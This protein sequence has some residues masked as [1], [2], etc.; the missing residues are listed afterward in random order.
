MPRR[1]VRAVP[2][3][4]LC[5]I[6]GNWRGSSSAVERYA[7]PYPAAS[8]WPDTPPNPGPRQAWT[9]GPRVGGMPGTPGLWALRAAVAVWTPRSAFLQESGLSQASPLA[10]LEP[11]GDGGGAQ[12]VGDSET[13]GGL[14]PRRR[15]RRSSLVRSELRLPETFTRGRSG[16]APVHRCVR[17]SAGLAWFCQCCLH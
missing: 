15:I 10:G 5:S 7:L 12:V 9:A 13:L 3:N 8:A 14:W 6:T 2:G 16:W 11:P 1:G 17:T 4:N